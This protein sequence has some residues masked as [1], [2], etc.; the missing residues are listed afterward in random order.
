MTFRVPNL[1]A[2]FPPMTEPSEAARAPVAM[3]QPASVAARTGS[4]IK[5]ERKPGSAGAALM[6]ATCTT[7]SARRVGASRLCGSGLHSPS[8][9]ARQR[10]PGTAGS[11]PA[12][13]PLRLAAKRG[14]PI[15]LCSVTLLPG[16]SGAREPR[17]TPPDSR[18]P[19]GRANEGGY[20]CPQTSAQY[21]PDHARKL[22]RRIYISQNLRYQV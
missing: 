10:T 13:V 18:G 5:V 8:P 17:R 15:T 22:S 2:S 21:P 19:T 6:I 3:I 1:A 4:S 16:D 11:P 12:D 7:K 14:G 20:Q 9:S